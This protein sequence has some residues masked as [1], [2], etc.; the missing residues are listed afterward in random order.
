MVYM[1]PWREGSAG[2]CSLDVQNIDTGQLP[3]RTERLLCM[4]RRYG[5]VMAQNRKG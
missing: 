5:T 1:K 4:A 2:R 3:E